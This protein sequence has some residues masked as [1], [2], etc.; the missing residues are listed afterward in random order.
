MA[1]MLQRIFFFIIPV[2]VK[3]KNDEN[4]DKIHVPTKYHSRITM[5]TKK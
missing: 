3:H 1:C 4:N 2:R 5:I